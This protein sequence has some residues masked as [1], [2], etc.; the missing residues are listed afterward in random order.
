MSNHTLQILEVKLTQC[1]NKLLIYVLDQFLLSTFF[2]G[3]SLDLMEASWEI[4]PVE[5]KFGYA[6]HNGDG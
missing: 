2:I 5:A 1:K 3:S 6:S 4:N